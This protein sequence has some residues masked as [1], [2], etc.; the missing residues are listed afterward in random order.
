MLEQEFAAGGEAHAEVSVIATSLRGIKGA[1]RESILQLFKALALVREDVSPPLEA[2]CLMFEVQ[3]GRR[4]SVLEIRRYLKCL[5]DRSL[6]LGNVDACSLHDIVRDY[7]EEIHGAAELQLAHHRLV[8]L[9]RERR[10]AEGW[11]QRAEAS[12]LERYVGGEID[13]HVRAALALPKPAMHEVAELWLDD[14]VGE[15]QDAIPLAAA[16]VLGAADTMA[17]AKQAE[18]QGCWWSAAL[19]W[20][21]AADAA[22]YEVASGDAAVKPLALKASAAA[23]DN[24]RPGPGVCSQAEKNQFEFKLLMT[25]V[26]MY[27]PST[28]AMCM[29]KLRRLI[30]AGVGST[31]ETYIAFFSAG[32]LTVNAS[33]GNEE[34]K[35]NLLSHGQQLF[36]LTVA[37]LDAAAAQAD[38]RKRAEYLGIGMLHMTN[39]WACMP[40]ASVAQWDSVLGEDGKYCAE[41]IDLYDFHTLSE[42]LNRQ[43]S[44]DLVLAGTMPWL[45]LFHY[46]DLAGA[47]LAVDTAVANLRLVPRPSTEENALNIMIAGMALPK[48]MLCLGRHDDAAQLA[49][50]LGF[51]AEHVNDTMDHIA[52]TCDPLP[53]DLQLSIL[54]CKLS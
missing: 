11:G 33:V 53:S 42:P 28:M 43:V 24:T 13:H 47:N 51:D 7:C 30:A 29:T 35:R 20:S 4:P 2:L 49:R 39:W 22:F 19:R 32:F 50:E 41:L 6:V 12:P 38:L 31:V 15:Q 17:L 26:G 25:L 18:A 27:D 23:L 48:T 1:Q 10:P 8:E 54:I 40:L 3:S 16:R 21:A 5:I 45:Q 52:A 46:I 34:I 36:D 14:F 37:V 9:L 44:V